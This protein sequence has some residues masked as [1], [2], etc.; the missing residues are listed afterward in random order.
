MDEVFCKQSVKDIFEFISSRK[1]KKLKELLKLI[2]KRIGSLTIKMEGCAYNS[3]TR[4][5]HYACQ[6]QAPLV[7]I[8][9]LFDVDPLAIFEEDDKKRYPLHIACTHGC[10][11]EAIMYLLNKNPHVAEN[12]VRYRLPLLLAIKSHLF[13]GDHFWERENNNLI[14]ELQVYFGG[15]DSG[16]SKYEESGRLKAFEYAIDRK[17]SIDAVTL[18]HEIN[19]ENKTKTNIENGMMKTLSKLGNHSE[20]M[21]D[22]KKEPQNLHSDNKC[23]ILSLKEYKSNQE[24]IDHTSKKIN[25]QVPVESEPGDTTFKLIKPLPSNKK[26]MYWLNSL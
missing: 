5:L 22:C 13:K 10:N 2:L 15:I 16:E 1:W 4:A 14:E 26:L 3:K 25:N 11:P 21:I 9:L 6:Y 20:R 23:L 7:V 18:L 8:K 19:K 12:D 24:V 17:V